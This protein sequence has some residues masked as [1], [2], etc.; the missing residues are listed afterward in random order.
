[1]AKAT[2][3]N[4]MVN[5]RKQTVIMMPAIDLAVRIRNCGFWNAGNSAIF[6]VYE[7]R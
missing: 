6:I 5:P 7:W 2:F 1:M 3:T 4:Q